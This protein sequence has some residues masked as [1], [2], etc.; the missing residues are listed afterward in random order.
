M[1]VSKTQI[2][3]FQEFSELVFLK[4]RFYF[5]FENENFQSNALKTCFR[6]SGLVMVCLL[7]QL[8]LYIY[9]L[10]V[11]AASVLPRL[12]F[13]F[14]FYFSPLQLKFNLTAFTSI[15]SSVL[16]F[17]NTCFS[18][19]LF[20]RSNLFLFGLSYFTSQKTK[21]NL[22]LECASCKLL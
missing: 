2:H 7:H 18:V 19:F 3:V 5:N 21:P 6:S 14:V 8:T 12:C 17:F 22:V 20:F 10:S 13:H 11:S 4:P 1:A 15:S 16:S 9:S